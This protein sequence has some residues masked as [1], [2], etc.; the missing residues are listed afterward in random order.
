MS[1]VFRAVHEE[2]GSIVAVKVLPRTLAK[3]V[4]LLQRFLREAKSA[5]A[6]DHPNIVAIY[7]RGFD[8]GRHYLVLEYVEG[9]DLH[10]RVRMNGPMAPDD[11]V[12]FI[13]E[14]A[15]GLHYAA[16]QGMVHRD[17]K[18]ANLL[19]TPDGHAKIIDLGLALQTEDEDERVTREGT[20]VGTVDYM[21]PEQA[22][23]SRQTSERSDI[24]SLG[25]TFYFLLT[26]S[27]PYPGGSLS[28]KLARHYKAPI[29]D[30]REHR[31]DVSEE[32]SLLIRKMMEKKPERRFADYLHLIAALDKL[33]EPSPPR[34]EEPILDALIDDDDDD[35][36]GLLP[37][38]SVTPGSKNDSGDFA[39]STHEQFLMAEIVDD[40][41]DDDEPFPVPP[42]TRR[43][44]SSA[45]KSRPRETPSKKES[46]RP[47]DEFSL[48]DLAALDAADDD[49]G[50]R[51][52]GSR[53]A[54]SSMTVRTSK[55]PSEPKVPAS[56]FQ[57]MIEEEADEEPV[58]GSGGPTRRSIGDEVPLKTWIAAGVLI[59][60]SLAIL[61]FGVTTIIA[62]TKPAKPPEITETTPDEPVRPEP[63]ETGNTNPRLT[64]QTRPTPPI[65][66]KTVTAPVTTPAPTP[67][68]VELVAAGPPPEEKNYTADWESRLFPESLNRPST[69]TDRS[70]IVV[71]RAIEA[72]DEVQA[73]S[74][75][76]A[77]SRAVEVVE[78]ADTGPF[79]EDDCQ[80][81]S[82]TRVIRAREGIRPMIRIDF[83]SNE[84][85]KEQT[86]KVILGGTKTDHLI[87]EGLDIAVDVRDLPDHQT[88]LFLCQG[89][90]LT[91]RNCSLTVVNA[92]D[93]SRV[94]RFSIFRVEEGV[95]P[96][97]IVLER[98][99]I[100][101]PVRTL[102]DIGS[103][104]ASIVFDRSIVI[105]DSGPLIVLEPNE[106]A[107]RTLYFHRSVIATRGPVL[108]ITGRSPLP[109]VRS[110][111]STFARVDGAT[112]CPMIVSKTSFSGE[113]ASV[114][115]WSGEDNVFV[116]WSGWLGSN[117]EASPR[118]AG[119]EK[120]RT[121][122]IGSDQTSVDS[123][124]PWPVSVLRDDLI[125]VDLASFAPDRRG[126]LY[127]IATPHPRLKDLTIGS[128]AKLTVPEL[129][130]SMIPPILSP[131]QSPTMGSSTSIQPPTP[132]KGMSVAPPVPN[133]IGPRAKADTPK[134]KSNPASNAPPRPPENLN[135]TFNVLDAPWSGDL[136]AF[137]AEKIVEGT[138]RA[139]IQVRGSG[140]FAMSPIKLADGLSIGLFGDSTEGAKIPMLTFVPKPGVAGRSMI[141][142]HRGDLAIANLGFATDGTNRPLH[143][144]Y[145]EDSLLGLQHCRF[146]EPGTSTPTVGPLIAFVA[147]SAKPIAERVG[148][149]ASATNRPTAHLKNCLIWT[150]GEAISA[151]LGRGVVDLENCL[152]ISGGPAITLLPQKVAAEKFEADLV[153]ERCTI[154]VDKTSIHLGPWL[155]DPLGPSRP[156]LISTR[157][158]VFPKTQTGQSGALLQVD[159]DAMARG[160]LFWQSSADIYDLNRFLA[161]TGT[162]PSTIPPA[163]LK[164]QWT[165]LWGLQHTRTDQG[166]NPRRNDQLLR[167]KDKERPKPGKVVPGALELD[168]KSF[169]DEGVDFALLPPSPKN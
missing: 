121:T 137:L 30:V 92:N 131:S 167:Y 7:D 82:K 66:T 71:R 93:S 166:P 133:A 111:G 76:L 64:R 45:S 135:L 18:P 85:V 54:P 14:V 29:P 94:N 139:T 81:S 67:V 40:D 5:G 125:P 106:K 169:K 115:D 25:C 58:Y 52:S 158:C 102:F 142:L 90:E 15:E 87:L 61:G 130:S 35:E 31:T 2:T 118:L 26:G 165:D 108:E 107:A 163:D 10:D 157:R 55:T 100:R 79:F 127:R 13:R 120:I 141:E 72:G 69:V 149:L 57:A 83:T 77:L 74:L 144:I 44:P 140:V 19:M 34:S 50:K 11:A 48:A 96:N 113:S 112:A 59:G 32:L 8:Q 37:T 150:G 1:S 114:L 119:V 9:R 47:A 16:G 65:P 73:P 155:G 51:R 21:A 23:D 105:G 143:W 145:A 24:Y 60:L 122:W 20:T 151:E 168:A 110:L 123:P 132:R 104:R 101:G 138:L 97:R 156:W 33:S 3:N 117:L 146:R 70:K 99:M 56:S 78:I 42:A 68:P 84:I 89:A 136:G 36:I 124:T 75:A 12:R 95:K 161:P 17:V 134:S 28:D 53:A 88:A 152:I 109:L 147:R 164:K 49:G 160:T 98:S 43:P 153:M 22:R 62:M 38:E 46:T 4:T 39:P 41:D 154:A 129:S 86:A 126:T 159:P 27:A 103:A 80:I 128:L 6:L 148:P 116:G 162:Q 63:V 91:L